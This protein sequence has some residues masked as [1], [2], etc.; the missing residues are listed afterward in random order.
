MLPQERTQTC[1]DLK[2]TAKV[3]QVILT[4]SPARAPSSP[5]GYIGTLSL[6]SLGEGFAHM[7]AKKQ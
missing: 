7:C 5:I 4:E 3:D 6:N 1:P 2:F